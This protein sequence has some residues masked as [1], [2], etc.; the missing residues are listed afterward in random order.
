MKDAGPEGRWRG[1]KVDR[2]APRQWPLASVACREVC[3]AAVPAHTSY[4]QHENQS[5]EGRQHIPSA[6]T[7]HRR[8]GSIYP[9]LQQWRGGQEAASWAPGARATPAKRLL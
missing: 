3:A 8:G 5:Q 4:T 6:K 9:A 1:V 7:N 2:I